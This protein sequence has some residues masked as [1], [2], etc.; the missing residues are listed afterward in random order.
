M[1]IRKQDETVNR[2]EG[3]RTIDAP[4]LTIDLPGY[5]EQI[6]NEKKWQERD[7]NAITVF[8]D[9]QLTIVLV[10]MHPTAEIRTLRP[11]HL[12][13]AQV[14]EGSIQLTI[15][16]NKSTLQKGQMTVVHSGQPYNLMALEESLVLLTVA[17]EENNEVGDTGF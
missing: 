10:A 3:E 7:H 13:T 9:D 16:E 1:E 15:N 12:W 11:E 4:F 2:P 17:S 5:I 6:K 8:K 14:L